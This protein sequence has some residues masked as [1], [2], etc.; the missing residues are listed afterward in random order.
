MKTKILILVVLVAVGFILY[1]VFSEKMTG[2]GK[3]DGSK[4]TGSKAERSSNKLVMEAVLAAKGRG[5][6][7]DATFD[8]GIKLN[9]FFYV[10]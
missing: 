5:F 9:P 6:T 3:D 10:K 8:D 4:P 2:E 7:E 1:N